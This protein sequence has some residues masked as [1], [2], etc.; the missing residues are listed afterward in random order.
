MAENEVAVDVSYLDRIGE[1]LKIGD[2]ISFS[3]YDG[4][5]EYFVLSGLT[6]TGST[7]DVYPIYFSEQYAERGKSVERYFI[8]SCRTN[9]GRQKYDSR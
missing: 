2:T 7:S 1:N 9:K 6:D 5:Q 8:C 3:F 4:T